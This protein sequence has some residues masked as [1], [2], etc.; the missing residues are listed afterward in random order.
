[1][2]WFRES[3]G[4]VEVAFTDRRGGVST[5]G[6]DSLNLGSAGGDTMENVVTNHRRVAEALG[7]DGLG[8]MSQVHG[9][10]VVAVDALRQDGSGTVPECDA[11]V[12]DTRGLA[13]LVRVA[14]CVPVLLADADAG[15][16]AAVHA[17]RAGLVGAVVPAAVQAL[18]ARGADALR[19]WVGPR[20]CG[21]C[22]ELPAEMA[23]AVEAAV[24]GTRSTTSWG[25]PAVDVGAGVV[26][27]LRA[28]GVV[29]DDLGAQACTIEDERLFSYRRQG[30]ESGRFGGVV[31]LR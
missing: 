10:S 26:A 27:Q 18:R 7:V 5:E 12:T 25:T 21:S 30:T 23:D 9:A 2:F 20:A 4:D 22:Y 1:M 11:L 19:S 15:L 17:G 14:D 6:R 24:P 8:S 16:V 28:A 13:L 29:V 3:F 31:V